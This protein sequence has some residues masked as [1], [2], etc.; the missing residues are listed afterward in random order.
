MVIIHAATEEGSPRALS[1][2]GVPPFAAANAVVDLPPLTLFSLSEWYGTPVTL[3]QEMYD[4]F[5]QKVHRRFNYK[6]GMTL[7]IPN[8]Q[9][10]LSLVEAHK[11]KLVEAQVAAIRHYANIRQHFGLKQGQT[12]VCVHHLFPIS[13]AGH[14][15]HPDNLIALGEDAHHFHAHLDLSVIVKEWQHAYSVSMMAHHVSFSWDRRQ[16]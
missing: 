16:Q 7:W 6:V 4:T 9:K 1:E 2:S 3:T 14:P 10:L 5:S 8:N 12:R 11:D 15:T 13:L